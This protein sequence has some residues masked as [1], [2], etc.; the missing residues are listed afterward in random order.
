VK[1]LVDHYL[2]FSLTKKPLLLAWS[3][4]MDFLNPEFNTIIGGN[5]K[6]SILVLLI[7]MLMKESQWFAPNHGEIGKC[8]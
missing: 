8:F 7:P 5:L 4:H 6:M 3:G 1:V 2:E